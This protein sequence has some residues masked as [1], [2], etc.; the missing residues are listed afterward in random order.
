MSTLAYEPMLSNGANTIAM[1]VIFNQQALGLS[2][3]RV[4]EEGE[5]KNGK[6]VLLEI[7][8]LKPDDGY[9]PGQYFGNVQIIFD[10]LRP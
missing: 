3:Q 8:A 5:A 9:V 7:A 6:R 2:P 4:V 10:A 1:K